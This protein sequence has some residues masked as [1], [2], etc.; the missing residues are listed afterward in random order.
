MFFHSRR[1]SRNPVFSSPGSRSHPSWNGFLND[2]EEVLVESVLEP[3][4]LGG[5]E[6]DGEHV[7][8]AEFTTDDT[9]GLEEV[10]PG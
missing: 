3:V 4:V 10:Q 2:L 8:V 9:E 6:E 7:G 1:T 5:I